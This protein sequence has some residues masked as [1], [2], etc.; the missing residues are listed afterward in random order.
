MYDK[1][2]DCDLSPVVGANNVSVGTRKSLLWRKEVNGEAIFSFVGC[3]LQAFFL[4]LLLSQNIIIIII[5]KK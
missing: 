4:L 5:T 2:W 1:K 3:C